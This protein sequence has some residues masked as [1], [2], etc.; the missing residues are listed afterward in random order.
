MTDGDGHGGEKTPSNSQNQNCA[1]A[2]LPTL[3]VFRQRVDQAFAH[4]ML[5]ITA[6]LHI[7]HKSSRISGDILR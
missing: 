6:K 5:K 7:Y 4:Q 1:T 3:T 2:V